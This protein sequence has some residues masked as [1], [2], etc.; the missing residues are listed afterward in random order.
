MVVRGTQAAR[1]AVAARLKEL[2]AVLLQEV[3]VDVYSV[4]PGPETPAGALKAAEVDGVLGAKGSVALGS[5]TLVIGQPGHLRSGRSTSF[6]SDYD[7]EVAEGAAIAKPV[8]R[9]VQEGLDLRT[10]VGQALDG[11]LIV[12]FALTRAGLSEPLATRAIGSTKIGD[13]QLPRVRSSIAAG[14]ALVEDG[15]GFL[16]RHEGGFG[17]ATLVRVRRVGGTAPQATA[18]A[19]RVVF[20]DDTLGSPIVAQIPRVHDDQRSEDEKNYLALVDPRTGPLVRDPSE[21]GQEPGTPRAHDL[22]L[23]FLGEDLQRQVMVAGSRILLRGDPASASRVREVLAEPGEGVRGELHR[24]VPD[25]DRRAPVGALEPGRSRAE[26][27]DRR[28]RARDG[29]GPVPDSR[30]SRSGRPSSTRRSRSRRKS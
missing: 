6:V 13:V 19:S 14:A 26:A 30:R 28:G 24:R 7:V 18:A 2:T 16:A 3:R 9:V 10:S 11:R 22:A 4:T 20:A 5:T 17:A 12:R 27:E 21:E 8:I 1:D 29:R 15:G 25:R 23:T